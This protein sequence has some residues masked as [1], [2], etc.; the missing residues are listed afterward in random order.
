[1]AYRVGQPYPLK[2]NSKRL[3]PSFLAE[4]WQSGPRRQGFAGAAAKRALD[5]SGPLRTPLRQEGMKGGFRKSKNALTATGLL[6]EGHFS[7]YLT[8][9]FKV[10]DG[11]GRKPLKSWR[12]ELVGERGF[13]PPTPW[14]R[15]RCSTRL[16]HSPT[17]TIQAD[18]DGRPRLYQSILAQQLRIPAPAPQ[19]QRRFKLKRPFRSPQVHGQLFIHSRYLPDCGLASSGKEYWFPPLSI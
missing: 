10:L 6:M 5:C 9:G 8:R 3:L 1:M 14:S 7:T 16:S 18:G 12:F 4:G 19:D 11:Y 15:T 2:N 17:Q 13:E